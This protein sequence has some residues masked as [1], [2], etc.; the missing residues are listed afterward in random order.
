MSLAGTKRKSATDRDITEVG[1]QKRVS[2]V[3]SESSGEPSTGVERPPAHSTRSQSGVNT[4]QQSADTSDIAQAS[5]ATEF[6]P[7]I[8]QDGSSGQQ[9]SLAD[10]AMPMVLPAR[11]VFPIQIGDKLFRLSGASIS[12]D[13]ELCPLLLSV[14]RGC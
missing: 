4:R 11:K 14:L 10:T 2:R 7:T 1:Q 13:G 3:M 5:S 8:A 6:E 9:R 12:S